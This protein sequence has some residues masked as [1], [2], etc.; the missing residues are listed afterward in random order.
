M[1]LTV[2]LSIAFGLPVLPRTLLIEAY[3]EKTEILL[4]REIV[5]LDFGI[6]RSVPA[7]KERKVI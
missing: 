3:G 6:V 7:H 2:S 5:F 4:P 1:L